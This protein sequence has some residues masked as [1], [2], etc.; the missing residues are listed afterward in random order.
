[1]IEKQCADMG[2]LACVQKS[3]WFDLR[4][5]RIWIDQI[6]K[7]YVANAPQS[8]LLID[9]YSVHL[10]NEFV[11]EVNDL[12]T[13]VD[14]IPKGYTCVL[15]PVDV[16]VNAQ[17]KNF[18]RD[19]HHAWCLVTYPAVAQGDKFPTPEREDIYPWILNAFDQVRP[20]SI[21]K[22]FAHIGYTSNDL[23]EVEAG[24]MEDDFNAEISID[25]MQLAIDGLSEELEERLEVN[26]WPDE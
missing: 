23:L 17:F 11:T 14:Y 3:G 5:G 25:P 21:I 6:L 9:H 18:I 19:Q 10:C 26:E 8:F 4:V 7:P 22:T 1:M 24:P 16:G 2:W 13:D 15:Q 12:G 20:D